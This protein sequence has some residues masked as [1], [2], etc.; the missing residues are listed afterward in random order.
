M[1]DTNVLGEE[2]SDDAMDSISEALK[3][4][5][6]QRSTFGA[7]QNRLEHSLAV[8]ENT[9]ENTTAAESRIRDTD[10]AEAAV[11]H[12]KE[13]I[14]MQTAQSILS[15]SNGNAQNVLTLLK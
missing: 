13:S 7:Y 1:E 9:A 2:S 10:M 3:I 4:V 5:S 12:S 14:L 8:N 11:A 6:K 15:Q